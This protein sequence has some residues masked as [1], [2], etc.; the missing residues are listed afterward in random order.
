MLEFLDLLALVRGLL[1]VSLNTAQHWCTFDKLNIRAIFAHFTRLTV[2]VTSRPCSYY[3]NAFC[4]CILARYFLVQETGHLDQRMYLVVSD[5]K[6][7]N[8]GCMVIVETIN[9]LDA[10]HRKEANFFMGSPLLF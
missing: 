2:L 6:S 5:L 9:G 7:G 8:H 4:L 10:F 1:G 3:L